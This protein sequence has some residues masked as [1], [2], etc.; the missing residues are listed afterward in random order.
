MAMVLGTFEIPCALFF[1]SSSVRQ[2]ASLKPEAL[3]IKNYIKSFAVLPFYDVEELYICRDDIL[4]YNIAEDHVFIDHI[5]KE[6][7]LL[8]SAEIQEKLQRFHQVVR[9]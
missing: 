4:R 6:F 8:S 7:Q 9:F 1:V 3:R 5:P 2:F